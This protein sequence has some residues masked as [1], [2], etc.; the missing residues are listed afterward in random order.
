LAGPSIGACIATALAKKLNT[1]TLQSSSVV[2]SHAGL[3]DQPLLFK[4]AE[5]AQLAVKKAS[6]RA[7]TSL[8]ERSFSDYQP[9]R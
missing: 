9:L 3:K 8:V 4:A 6:H 5:L 7:I 2:G 1:G